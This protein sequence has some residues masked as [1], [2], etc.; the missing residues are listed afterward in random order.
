MPV[1]Q[2][3]LGKM[4][5]ISRSSVIKYETHLRYPTLPTLAKLGR[6]LNLTPQ[7]FVVLAYDAADKNED[8]GKALKRYRRRLP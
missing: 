6:I 4:V 8:F 2:A 5:G 3:K 7:E 1:S